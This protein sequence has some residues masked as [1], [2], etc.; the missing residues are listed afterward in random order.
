MQDHPDSS[1]QASAVDREDRLANLL[2]RAGEQVRQGMPPRV[3]DLVRQH[4]D[5]ADEIRELLP[6]VLLAEEMAAAASQATLIPCL[7]V[8]AA[9]GM[10]AANL[11]RS[12]GDYELE[13]ELGRGGMGVVYKARQ[14]S[15]SR[16]VAVK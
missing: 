6:V 1:S 12:F 9:S 13:E 14:H 2:S 3:D 15:L 4:A 8:A 11:P 7:C 10:K 16:T 5:L